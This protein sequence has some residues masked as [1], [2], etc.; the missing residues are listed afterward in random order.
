MSSRLNYYFRQK[1]TEAELD[2]GF[3]LLEDADQAQATDLAFI[4]VLSGMV[5]TQRGAGPNLTVD[6]SAGKAYDKDGSRISFTGTQNVNVAV[7]ES[8]VTTTVSGGGNSKIVSVFAK[9]LRVLSDPRTDGN[10][11]TVYFSEAEGF[12]FVIR[13][14]AEAVS[15]TPPPLDPAFILLADITRSFGGTT[16]TNAMIDTSAASRREDCFVTAGSPHMLRRG[17]VKDG[18]SD[19]LGWLNTEIADR[20]TA[21]TGVQTNLD[22]HI[23]DATDAHDA[24]AVSYLGS[25]NWT[26]ATAVVATDVEGAIDEIVSDLGATTG[27]VKI[28][29]PTRALV[30]TFGLALGSIGSQLEA[31]RD[32]IDQGVQGRRVHTLTA[33]TTLG[34]HRQVLANTTGGAFTLT[35]PAPALGAEFWVK[36]PLGTWGTN[37]LTLARFGAEKIENVVASRVFSADFG[38]FRVFSNGTDWF[39]D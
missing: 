7:D 25:G 11:V 38:S 2:S 34:V 33:N 9:F 32:Y 6:V 4:G 37:N 17:L 26:D 31:I 27:D 39:L 28:G 19:V 5:V 8:A 20:G 23:N 18:L 36:D 12:A 35:L 21:V 30:Y 24:S 13:Q 1:V 15:P 22:N 10:S 3:A 16:I 29:S 14:G